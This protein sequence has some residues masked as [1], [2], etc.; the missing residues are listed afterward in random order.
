M[1]SI[2][3]TTTHKKEELHQADIIVKDLTFIHKEDL[4]KLLEEKR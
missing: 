3:L 1:R 2:G 4:L